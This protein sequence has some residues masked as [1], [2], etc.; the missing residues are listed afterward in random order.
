MHFLINI[1]IKTM[2]NIDSI[3]IRMY[4]QGFGDCFLLQFMEGDIRISSMLIDCG[5][6]A[7]SPAVE[8]ARLR[9]VVKDLTT[10]L[11]PAGKTKPELDVLVIT[12]EHWDH[13]SGFNPNLFKDFMISQIWMAWTENPSDGVAQQ[14][15]KRMKQNLTALHIVNDKIRE[16]TAAN[17][18]F[19]KQYYGG[20]TYFNLRQSFSG[21]LNAVLGFSNMEAVESTITTE[22]GI[23]IKKFDISLGTEKA[24]GTVKSLAASANA[25]KYYGPGNV[26]LDKKFPGL[27]LYVLGPP[28]NVKLN[29]D[30]PS[31]KGDDKETYF[32]LSDTSLDGFV[33]GILSAHE[34]TGM[35]P[36]DGSPF[37]DIPMVTKQTD[38]AKK[39]YASY[40]TEAE[41]WRIIED[42]WLDIGGAL[43]LQM[44][45][46][47]NNTSL[48]LALEFIESGKVILFPGDAQVGSWESWHD[49]TFSVKKDNQTEEI[50]AKDLLNRTAFYKVG[51]HCS[52]NATLRAKGLELMESEELVAFIPEMNDQYSGIPHPELVERLKQ[53]TRGRLIFSADK[54]F[55]L[56]NFKTDRP[57]GQSV[58]EW[59]E[60]TDKLEIDKL[61]IEYT[62]K[63]EL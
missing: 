34:L 57:A 44:D 54:N 17:E 2:A 22:S 48:V 39:L 13:V 47:T 35:Q 32:A 8:G 25:I 40:F 6:K 45:D 46:D 19:Y 3:K 26:I 38:E 7:A 33:Q 23:V 12:H 29:K 37:S 10:I 24:M 52:H 18:D 59:K 53:K 61:F 4:R 41:Q 9:D 31:G 43:A 28:K 30:L 51:H 14:I 42:D 27:R 20:E 1:K 16:S 15:N 60:F 5:V 63:A 50:T 56:A 58:A 11:T 62:M 49:L 36:D 21:S 55:P